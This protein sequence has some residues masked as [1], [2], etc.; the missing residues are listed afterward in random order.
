METPV[1]SVLFHRPRP[2]WTNTNQPKESHMY[3][4]Y[5]FIETTALI[6]MIAIIAFGPAAYTAIA[7]T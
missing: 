7:I 6:I 2:F 5:K 3:S 1:L 4:I